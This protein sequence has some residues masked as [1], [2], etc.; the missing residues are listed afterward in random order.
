MVKTPCLLKWRLPF[1][2]RLFVLV[3]VMSSGAETSL[4]VALSP[5]QRF[6]NFARND[7][8]GRA[9]LNSFV[10]EVPLAF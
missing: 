5:N 4:D 8:G 2:L 1:S 10:F 6:L 3:D 9:C 7:S